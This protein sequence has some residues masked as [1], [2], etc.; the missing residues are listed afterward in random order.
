MRV[1]VLGAG[2]QGTLYG[3]RL[4]NAG[5][6]VTLV[7]RGARA[8]QLRTNDAAIVHAL[9]GRADVLRLPVIE[10]LTTDT[11]ADLCLVTVRREQLENVLPVASAARRIDR[12]LIMVNHA[13]GS[14]RLRAALGRDRVVLGFPGAAGSVDDGVAHYV[15]VAE[16]ATAI[17]ATA[18]DVAHALRRAGFRVDL[19]N[20]MDAWLKR[21]AVF[22]TAL[23]GALYEARGDARRLA[24]E[25]ELVRSF[26]LAVREG[27]GALDGIGV[28]PASLGLRTILCL[29]PMPFAVAYWRR[30]LRSPRGDLYFGRH[31]RH[32]PREM[33]AL[34][35]DVQLLVGDAPLP[36]LRALFDAVDGAARDGP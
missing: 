3:V 26:V 7:A 20:D 32:A 21:H 19:V 33:A 12:F 18:P 11:V 23:C 6:D 1:A 17:E 2:L 5:H 30:L 28:A 27:W 36:H 35:E 16:Q 22:V 14:T 10:Q 34:A 9:T 31:A 15:E 13:D 24:Q 29:V 8:M 4:A 25:P